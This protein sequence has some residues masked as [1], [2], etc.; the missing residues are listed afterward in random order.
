MGFRSR[1][2]SPV[3]YANANGRSSGLRARL[4]SIAAN[5]SRSLTAAEASAA[6]SRSVPR[7]R[8]PITRSVSSTTT[9]SIPAVRPSSSNSGL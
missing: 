7:R 3:V 6:R 4:R 1:S 9:H 8:S 2:S 5:S